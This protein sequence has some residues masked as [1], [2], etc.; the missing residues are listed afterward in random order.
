MM[1]KRY[2]GDGVYAEVE[3][4]MIKLTT[5][6]GWMTSNTIFLEPAV[7]EA[8]KMFVDDAIRAART[9]APHEAPR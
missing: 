5:S 7:F 1:P 6:N 8:L 3:R 2:L 9:T 4:G